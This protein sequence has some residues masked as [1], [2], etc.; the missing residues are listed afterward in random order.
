MKIELWPIEKLIPY[1][2]NPRKK[3]AINEVAHS[4]EKFGWQQVIVVDKENVIIIGHTRRLAALQLGLTQ[5]P[6][7]VASDLTPEQCRQL[8]IADNATSAVSEWDLQLL[9]QECSAMPEIDFKD[10]G[11]DLEAELLKAQGLVPDDGSDESQE[12]VKQNDKITVIIDDMSQKAEIK[13]AVMAAI[14]GL[15]AHVK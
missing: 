13:A 8:R 7:K 9:M 2:K 5:V 14:E 12:G 3:Q 11:L 6:V 10:F 1:D 15:E 4:I